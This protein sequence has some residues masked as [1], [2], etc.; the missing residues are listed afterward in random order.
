VVVHP[1]RRVANTGR[2]SGVDPDDNVTDVGF[3]EIATP[4]SDGG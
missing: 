1:S 3:A 2:L 4:P